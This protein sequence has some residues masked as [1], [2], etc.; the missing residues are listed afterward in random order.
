MERANI[1]TDETIIFHGDYTYE[2]GYKLANEIMA[3]ENPVSAIFAA[4]DDMAAGAIKAIKAAGKRVPEDY[5]VVGFD[6]IRLSTIIEPAITTIEQPK[7]EMGIKAMEMLFELI[8]GKTLE[9]EQVVLEHKLIIRES[10]GAGL[11]KGKKAV[12]MDES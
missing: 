4:T 3:L 1:E 5:A 2:S 8:D 10:C 11:K 6:N 9:E 12:R 7:L